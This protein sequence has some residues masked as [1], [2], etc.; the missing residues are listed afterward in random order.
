MFTVLGIVNNSQI[1]VFECRENVL[2][3]CIFKTRPIDLY[4]KRYNF[5]KKI[6]IGSEIQG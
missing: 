2:C 5:H 4:R 3:I 6:S 1:N